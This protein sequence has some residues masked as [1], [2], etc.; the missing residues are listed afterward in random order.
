MSD[1]SHDHIT[2]L[3][4]MD[5]GPYVPRV[6]YE[7]A[8]ERIYELERQIG[9]LERQNERLRRDLVEVPLKERV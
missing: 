9:E 7:Q 8:V 1:P 6:K 5:H 4:D 3:T 2:E